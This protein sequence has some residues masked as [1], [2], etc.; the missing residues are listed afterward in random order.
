MVERVTMEE[1]P[2]IDKQQ[3]PDEV[4]LRAALGSRFNDYLQL[5][6]LANSYS[7]TWNFSKSSGWMLKVF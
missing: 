1:R 3:M 4:S 6:L 2:F 5:T 7:Q